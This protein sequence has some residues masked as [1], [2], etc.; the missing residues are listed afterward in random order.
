MRERAR[1]KAW[2]LFDVS[3]GS[4]VIATHHGRSNAGEVEEEA[5]GDGLRAT[6]NDAAT[7]KGKVVSERTRSRR[8]GR[9]G[10]VRRAPCRWD[11]SS[12]LSS[13]RGGWS[14]RPATLPGP[15]RGR[16]AS[17][18]RRRGRRPRGRR[19]TAGPARVRG[20]ARRPRRR[21]LPGRKWPSSSETATDF[22]RL[23]ETRRW[24]FGGDG[25]SSFQYTTPSKITIV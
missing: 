10:G 11:S 15:S 13:A 3:V 19:R 21:C 9:T 7:T 2:G 12:R 16:G 20:P 17:C 1:E 24:D 23:F 25:K 22:C 14:G 8:G 4:R 5:G 18:D 6:R